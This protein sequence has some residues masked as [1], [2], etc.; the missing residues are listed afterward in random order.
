M[1]FEEILPALRDGEKVR[2]NNGFWISNLGCIYLQKGF[3]VDDRT[4][5][6]DIDFEDLN[7]DDWEVVEK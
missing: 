7:A 5:H 4:N 3:V 2:R 6:Y 1:K